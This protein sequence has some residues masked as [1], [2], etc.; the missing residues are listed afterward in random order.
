MIKQLKTFTVNLVA[1]ANVATVILMLC[2]GYSD[3]LNPVDYPLL[4]CFGI[5]FPIF[6]I[7]NLL[8]LFFWLTFKWR[9]AWIPVVGNTMQ[10]MK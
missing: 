10:H 2:A 7:V 4:S 5:T 8:F 6:L 3:R 1:G 9:K